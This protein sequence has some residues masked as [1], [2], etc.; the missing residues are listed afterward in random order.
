MGKYLPAKADKH[1]VKSTHVYI[2]GENVG[3]N[4]VPGKLIVSSSHEQA[5]ITT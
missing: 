4:C 3:D 1:T 2:P 5:K